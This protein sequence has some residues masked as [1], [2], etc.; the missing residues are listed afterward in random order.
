MCFGNSPAPQAPQIQYVGPSEDDIRRNEEQ[1]A[2]FQQ[3][4]QTQQADAAASIQQQIDLANQRTAEIQAELDQEIASAQGDTSAAE[5]AAQEAQQK[6]IDAKKEAAAA[7]GASYTPFGAYGVTATQTEAPAA[8]TTK[9]ISKKKKEK[10]TLKIAQNAAA[11]S[12]GSGLNI[13]V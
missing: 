2:T 13:G 5:A 12:A 9:S 10:S 8:Q 6:A 4:L 3:Q 7:A 11:A 1:L